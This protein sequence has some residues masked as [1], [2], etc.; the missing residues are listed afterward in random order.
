MANFFKLKHIFQQD[1]YG[2]TETYYITNAGNT[3]GALEVCKKIAESRTALLST[4]AVLVQCQASQEPDP[5]WGTLAN[6]GNPLSVRGDSKVA[7]VGRAK[8]RGVDDLSPCDPWEGILIGLVGS[9]GA[10]PNNPAYR[11]NMILR[12]IPK[13]A[14]SGGIGTGVVF[15]PVYKGL[16]DAY[17]KALA[18]NT[19]CVRGAT[20]QLATGKITAV[21]EGV[22][23]NTVV[24]THTLA[25]LSAGM[26]VK[27]SGW[28]R[29][30]SRRDPNTGELTPTG[31][32]GV[33]RIVS[34]TVPPA[35]QGCTIASRAGVVLP[36]AN[37]TITRVLMGYFPIQNVPS[38]PLLR[39]RDTSHDRF[40]NRASARRQTVTP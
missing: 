21:A 38:A 20:K 19:I 18:D 24:L 8:V 17:I 5:E 30:G 28:P 29:P 26:K 4:D 31:Y 14:Y 2:W 39:K 23:A 11:R 13:G 27:I 35:A 3:T 16:L 15:S 37:N 22:V 6:P 25:G 33:H 9:V 7:T 40:V 32:N 34:V 1:E 36:P 10:D 12:G